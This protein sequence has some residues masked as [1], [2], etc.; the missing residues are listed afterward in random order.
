MKKNKK[1]IVTIDVIE[2]CLIESLEK[3]EKI[4]QNKNK[5]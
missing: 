4:T 5:S 1:F 2:D 3:V